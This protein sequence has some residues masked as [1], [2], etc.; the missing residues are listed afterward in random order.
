MKIVDF[1]ARPCY[2]WC[3]VKAR[4]PFER[5]F[6]KVREFAQLTGLNVQSVRA[7]IA[8]GEIQA[9]KIGRQ[10]FIPRSEV[11]RLGGKREQRD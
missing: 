2:L 9:Q 8:S 5:Q 3:H 10:F 6:F 1:R 4:Q 11:E 7:F